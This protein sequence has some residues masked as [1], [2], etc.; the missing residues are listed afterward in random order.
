MLT[1]ADLTAHQAGLGNLTTL[2]L[3][4]LVALWKS[5]DFKDR[6]AAARQ[7]RSFLPDAIAGYGLAAGALAADFY[8][9]VRAAAAVGGSFVATADHVTSPEATQALIN[10]GLAP[11][12]NADAPDPALA[13]SRLA[14]GFQRAVAGAD[15]QIII[16]NAR[17]DPEDVRYARHASANACTFCAMLTTH[18]AVYRSAASARTV[19]G[20]GTAK[21]FDGSKMDARRKGIRPRGTQALGEKFH[22]YCHC[23]VVPVWPGS[24]IPEP[25]YVADWREAYFA[26]AEKHPADT[27]AILAE[28]R[29]SLGTK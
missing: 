26:A 20:R 24:E 3:A 13:L 17:R 11:L 7:I 18:Q 16:A 4:D 14:G 8:D 15:R 9:E 12:F 25:P 19:V 21:L 27:K 10:W 5:L 22:D 1:L 28:M 2:A 6:S 23:I 29:A